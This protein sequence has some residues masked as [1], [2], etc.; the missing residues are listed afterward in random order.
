[1]SWGIA[2][3]ATVAAGIVGLLG[4]LIA[5]RCPTTPAVVAAG[6]VVAPGWYADPVGASA[7][8]YWDGAC[9]TRRTTDEPGSAWPVDP[10]E[11]GSRD[12][13]TGSEAIETP[14]DLPVPT[15]AKFAALKSWQKALIM[16][17]VALG[18]GVILVVLQSF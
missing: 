18:G 10:A 6:I 5:R 11:P 12:P 16:M 13:A 8:R 4:A 7:L 17:G 3:Y 15:S 2:V 14:A 1:M 9:W